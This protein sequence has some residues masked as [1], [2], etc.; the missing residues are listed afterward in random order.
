MKYLQQKSI[1][2]MKVLGFWHLVASATYT[3]T[4]GK[5][6]AK[7]VVIIWPEAD[8]VNTSIYP[9]V[10]TTNSLLI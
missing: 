2:D 9:G 4:V 5:V 6:L 8:Q 1:L 10:S 3:K 7:A